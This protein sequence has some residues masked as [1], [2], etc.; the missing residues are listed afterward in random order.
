M[1]ILSQS[2]WVV[3][4]AAG[5]TL[6]GL[7]YMA[8]TGSS[9]TDLVP[10]RV[11]PEYLEASKG[12]SII[13]PKVETFEKSYQN[14]RYASREVVLESKRV[15]HASS[16]RSA[17]ENKDWLVRLA[18]EDPHSAIREAATTESEY[19]RGI[20]LQSVVE[21]WAESDFQ[22]A[23]DWALSYGEESLL[24]VA[25]KNLTGGAEN[26]SLVFGQA[27]EVYG[28]ERRSDCAMAVLKGLCYSGDYDSAFEFSD[29]LEDNLS[30]QAEDVALS[31]WAR[32][33]PEEAAAFALSR[34]GTEPFSKVVSSWA[35]SDPAALA[36]YASE[37]PE[38][39]ERSHALSEALRSWVATD[40]DAAA[41]WILQQPAS[42]DLDTG[43]LSLASRSNRAESAP[44]EAVKWAELL[45]DN[46][47]RNDTLSRVVK[48][49]AATDRRAARAYLEKSDSLSSEMRSEL[50]ALFDGR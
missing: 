48:Q 23:F 41:K 10:E 17:L 19:L 25:L 21:S 9:P 11:A 22:A 43:L 1:K 37:L 29:T 14:E 45:Y 18:Q 3:Y 4:L 8:G 33:Q 36:S 27:L 40:E 49:W 24:K 32:Y 50:V 39:S 46:G 15:S 47:L 5:A 31:H 35:T 16:E 6:F 26:A 20:Y 2:K 7:G 44:R 30:R 12:E 28:A 42:K 13:S 34:S 38:S